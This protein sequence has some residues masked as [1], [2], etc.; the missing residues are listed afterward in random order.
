M[1]LFPKKKYTHINYN[2][3]KLAVRGSAGHPSERLRR[4]MRRHG[5][6]RMLA[7]PS[8]YKRGFRVGRVDTARAECW[9]SQASKRVAGNERGQHPMIY[10][11]YQSKLLMRNGRWEGKT[12]RANR[13]NPH[14]EQ[15]EIYVGLSEQ[16]RLDDRS[17]SP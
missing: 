13:N 16:S 14:T 2:M 5:G 10:S 8:M 1:P 15:I 4:E 17:R 12:V 11:L 7:E 9:R 6:S 3:Q